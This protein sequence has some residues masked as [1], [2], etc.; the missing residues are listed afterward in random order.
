MGGGLSAPVLFTRVR[1]GSIAVVSI[2]STVLVWVHVISAAFASTLHGSSAFPSVVFVSTVSRAGVGSMGAGFSE[3]H[4][5]AERSSSAGSGDASGDADSLAAN[6][7]ATGSAAQDLVINEILYDPAGTDEGLEFVELYNPTDVP[8]SLR[9]LALETGNGAAE[10]DWSL[11]A[12]WDSDYYVEAHGYVVIGEE[13]VSPRPQFVKQLDLQNGP[14]ACR[15][16][17]G[18]QIVD[19]VGWGSHTFAEYYEGTPCEDVASGISVGRL[20]DGVDTQDNSADFR[21]LSPPSPGRRNLC[22][23]DAGLVPGTLSTSPALPLPYEKTEISV[24]IANFGAR[25]L[26][27]GECLIE[28]FGIVDSVRNFLASTAT[29]AIAPKQSEIVS[30]SLLPEVETCVAIQ[31][32]LRLEDDENRGN[33]TTSI[34]L[35]VGE[36]DI[37]VN[38]IMYAPAAGEPEWVELFNRGQVSVDVRGWWIEDSSKKK[39][40][41]TSLPLVIA[42]GE[43]LVISQDKELFQEKPNQCEYRVVQPQGSWP[44]FNNYASDASGYA[45]AVC[46]RDSSGCISD[47]V[48][49][50]EAW[51]TRRYGSLERVSASV[52][53]RQ[54]ANWSSSVA[55]SGSTPCGRNSVSE[56]MRQGS[57]FQLGMSTRVISPNGDGIDDRVVFSFA[58]PSAGMRASLTVFDSDGRT[59]KRLLDQRRVGTVV[60]TIWDGLDEEG[61]PVTPGIYIVNLGVKRVDGGWEESRSTLVVAPQGKR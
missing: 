9:G 60:Q 15:L 58:L 57:A 52:S 55:P 56:A 26:A 6:Y 42:P 30:V 14:D 34:R 20:P 51:A 5:L 16:R 47:Y 48:A 18:T 25:E 39:A 61:R 23:V 35:R 31:A 29:R 41:L 21:A 44:S 12:Q 49:Y 37:V 36:G 11:G 4:T 1:P 13:A 46:I 19:L 24:E 27:D 3:A 8:L 38:E 43:F 59:M 45:D 28:F 10:G 22:I 7:R 50:G 17:K 54:A 2:V 40:C 33:D 53:S 32:T